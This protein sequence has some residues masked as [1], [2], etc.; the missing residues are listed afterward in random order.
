MQICQF[1]SHSHPSVSAFTSNR[2][3]NNLPD[4]Y[5]PW[6]PI[7]ADRALFIESPSERIAAAIRRYGFFLLAGGRSYSRP[8]RE[9][10]LA[11]ALSR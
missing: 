2:A 4:D 8:R 10:L 9:A 7:Y 5:A 1:A 11:E 6:F 3:G